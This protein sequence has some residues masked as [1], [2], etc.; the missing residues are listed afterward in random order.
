MISLNE[1]STVN[2]L[3]IYDIYEGLLSDLEDTLETGNNYVEEETLKSWFMNSKCNFRKTKKGYVLNGNFKIKDVDEKYNGPKIKNVY[4]NIA[5]SN[6]KLSNLENIFN[7]D[8]EVTGTLTIENNPN[9]TSLK[10]CPISC[11]TLVISGNKNLKDI[12]VAPNV[13]INAYISKNGKKFDKDKLRNKISVYK[14]IFCSNIDEEEII[15]ESELLMEAFKAPQLKIIN[16]SIKNAIKNDIRFYKG[17]K[18]YDDMNSITSVRWDKIESSDISE[19]EST[20]QKCLTTARAYISG[21]IKGIMAFMYNG[22]II[23]IFFRNRAYNLTEKHGIN[24]RTDYKS[25]EVIDFIKKHVD[26]VIFVELNDSVIDDFYKVRSDRKNAKKGAIALMKGRERTGEDTYINRID[27]NNIRYYQEIA[28]QNRERYEKKI[29]QLRAAK[30]IKNN[31]NFINLKK[32]IDD[33]FK[34]YTDILSKIQSN[35]SNY[36]YSDISW[37]HDSFFKTRAI[38]KYSIETSGLFI[39]I[40]KYMQI[41]ILTSNGETYYGKDVDNTLKEYEDA[42]LNII[43]HISSKLYYLE[44]K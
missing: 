23:K 8:C 3:N 25:S 26:S 31:S 20:D 32:Q 19:Y 37:L 36:D 18:E 6:T 28:D 42:I 38:K 43:N 7:V 12:D 27:T 14:H 44:H 9:L 1:L 40:D 35:P 2:I 16:D 33:V 29:I 15:S 4:G 30:A 11:G 21:K 39:L 24:L 5:I 10:G 13:M 34:R 22:N 41:C 17:F